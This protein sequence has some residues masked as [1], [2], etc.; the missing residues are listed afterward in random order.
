MFQPASLL[1]VQQNDPSMLCD[2][3]MGAFR[4][5]SST[6]FGTSEIPQI[7]DTLNTN[8]VP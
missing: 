1:F 4:I 2:R 7:E 6:P 8:T 5:H 3:F